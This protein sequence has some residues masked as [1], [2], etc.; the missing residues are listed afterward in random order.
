MLFYAKHTSSD[1]LHA[2]GS[3]IACSRVPMVG[4]RFENVVGKRPKILRS[5]EIRVA[6]L[7]EPVAFLL[8]DNRDLWR[9]L[10]RRGSGLSEHFNSGPINVISPINVEFFC[11][12][13]MALRGQYWR[14][15]FSAASAL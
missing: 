2:R 8:D 5:H 13:K 15:F 1:F 10:H 4:S 6:R 3:A 14:H 7:G 11:G 9:D 12:F